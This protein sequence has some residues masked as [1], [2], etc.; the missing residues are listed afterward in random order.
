[1]DS[2]TGLLTP[3]VTGWERRTDF[4]WGLR[5][6][7]G[8]AKATQMATRTAIC[9]ERRKGIPTRRGIS[10]AIPTGFPTGRCSGLLMGSRMPTGIDLATRMGK[11]FDFQKAILTE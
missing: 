2:Q 6:R 9:W 7:M 8:K 11:R 5:K 3:K 10:W 1:M 4:R